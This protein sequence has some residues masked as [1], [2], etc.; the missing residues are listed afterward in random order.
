[1]ERWQPHLGQDHDR[2]TTKAQQRE[3]AEAL[4]RPIEQISLTLLVMIVPLV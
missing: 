1:M 2:P 3:A 4:R